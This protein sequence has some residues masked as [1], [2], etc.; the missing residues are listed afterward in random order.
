MKHLLFLL[1]AVTLSAADIDAKAAFERLKTL[2]GEYQ[3]NKSTITYELVGNGTVVLERETIENMSPMV[4]MYHLDGDRL[5]LTH[6]CHA[7]NQPR[8]QARR[9]DAKTGEIRFEY[10]DG[11]NMKPADGHMHNATIRIED[12]KTVVAD[13][14]FF[15]NGKL[16]TTETFRYIKVK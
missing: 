6:Y 10:L 9:F 7:G 2:A 16:A 11:T 12:P 5:I 14:E 8:M 15:N 3:A 13:W 4:T 1:G